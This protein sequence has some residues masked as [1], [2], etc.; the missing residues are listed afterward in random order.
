MIKSIHHR[1][2]IASLL[3][4]FALPSKTHAAEV[5]AG[6]VRQPA[7]PGKY[8]LAA[9]RT[10]DPSTLHGKRIFGYQGWFSTADDAGPLDNWNHW[11]AD[12]K[13]PNAANF[14]VQMWPDLAEYEADELYDTDLGHPDGSVAR[15]YS[16]WNLKT[17]MRHFRWMRDYNLDGAVQYRFISRISSRPEYR[18]FYNQVLDNIRQSAEAYGRVFAVRYDISDYQG[19]SVVQDIQ[20]DWKSLV[21]EMKV[22]DSPRYLHHKGR[23]L[24]VLRNFGMSGGKRLITPA[25]AAELIKWFKTDAP[26]KYRVTVMGALP[27]YWRTQGRDVK[28]E[29]GSPAVFRSFDVVSAWPVGHFRDE[30]GADKWLEQVVIP[31]MKGCARLGM[32][33]IPAICPGYSFH[34][35]DPSKP[36]NSI[37]RCG[38]R[39]YW[40]RVDHVVSANATM[41]YNAIFDEVEEGT[42][43][44]KVLPNAAAQPAMSE[45]RRFLALD[46]DGEQLRSDWYLKLAD[47]AGR[48]LRKEI[49]PTEAR[50]I[51][52]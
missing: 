3:L 49:V 33:Y 2:A 47:Y 14:R 6:V 50:P 52:P 20:K 43:M 30:A 48:A 12:R 19:P 13:Q 15:V 29:P 23:P 39:F 9:P 41:I 28:P 51:D 27:G 38:G 22:T 11:S 37:P 18:V 26:E 34:N 7:A 42:A 17:V 21:D 8:Q 44:Y 36:Y 5:S 25:E 1:I 40:S 46:A 31:D 10:I 32:D 45:D 16:A 24:V 35:A 4:S